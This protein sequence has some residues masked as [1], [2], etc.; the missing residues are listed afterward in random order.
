MKNVIFVL[1]NEKRGSFL[2][3]IEETEKMNRFIQ[4]LRHGGLNVIKVAVSPRFVKTCDAPLF[5]EQQCNTQN[6]LLIIDHGRIAKHYANKG[7][8]VIGYER[9]HQGP[10]YDVGISSHQVEKDEANDF[11]GIGHLLQ[12]FDE[13]DAI[14][15]KRIF[16]RCHNIP[17][18]ICETKRCIIRE[19][20]VEDVDRLYEIYSEPSITEYMEDLFE[21]PKE[22]KEYTMQYIKN[23]YHMY[24]YGMWI[25]EEKQTGQIIGRAGL[26]QNEGMEGLE[27][28]Y[29]IAVPYQRKGYA[30]EVC[31][32]ILDYAW[33]N[34][35]TEVITSAI[36]KGNV[37]SEKLCQKLGFIHV[38][39]FVKNG[40]IY[41]KYKREK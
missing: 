2:S 34:L 32:A 18:K 24:G 33:E 22:E 3:I 17:W 39:E 9:Q 13:V 40:V 16:E 28:G 8:A 23:I 41:H 38:C 25:I 30:Y 10:Y 7:Y 35:E 31:S 15:L 5:D 19:I 4:E 1:E 6:T 14:Y 11:W 12:G 20:T 36:E 26:E 21:N 27:L 37:A 29:V